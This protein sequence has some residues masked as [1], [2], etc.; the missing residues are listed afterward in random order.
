M[1]ALQSSLAPWFSSFQWKHAL[2]NQGLW[3]YRSRN[4]FPGCPSEVNGKQT[5]TP[6]AFVKAIEDIP[7]RQYFP[8]QW[9][10]MREFRNLDA[11]DQTCQKQ[12]CRKWWLAGSWSKA[13]S[14]GAATD[15][16]IG[17]S[18]DCSISCEEGQNLR[19]TIVCWRYQR[20]ETGVEWWT[21][22]RFLCSENGISILYRYNHCT[23]L[24]LGDAPIFTLLVA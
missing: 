23:F 3:A 5:P 21:F 18:T 10:D 12:T 13:A 20:S 16:L 7:D 11:N 24:R 1:L 6:E 2:P 8:V 15:S 19:I 14:I 9:Y 22:D 17:W 4:Y